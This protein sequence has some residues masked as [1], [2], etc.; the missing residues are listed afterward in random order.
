MSNDKI[1][2]D[3]HL[4]DQYY[5]VYQNFTDRTSSDFGSKRIKP[6]DISVV[7]A[8]PPTPKS[9]KDW[10]I[11]GYHVQAVTKKAA[12]KKVNKLKLENEQHRL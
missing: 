9:M 10:Y 1:M 5:N 8:T 4:I 3:Y 7:P 11:D 12:L 2:P 6:K